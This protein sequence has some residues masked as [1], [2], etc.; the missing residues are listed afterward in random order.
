MIPAFE[1]RA[2]THLM[3]PWGARV[4]DLEELRR[5]VE[6]A[7]AEV[8]F[9]HTVQFPLRAPAAEQLP[10]DD[11]SAWVGGTL[12]DAE[13]AERLSFAVGTQEGGAAEMRGA[14]LA[15]IGSVPEKQRA[16]RRAP[17]GGELVFLAATSLS[18]PIGSAIHDADEMHDALIREEA[19]VWFYHLVEEPW[20]RGEAPLLAWLERAGDRRLADEIRQAARAGLPIEKARARVARRRRQR[21]LARRL[22]DAATQSEDQRREAGRQAVARFV[23]RGRR[24]EPGA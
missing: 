20:F 3:S 19:S 10:P 5:G 4:G 24:V 17:E 23:R 21:Q 13:T 16:A 6:A 9:R 18:F 1:L 14:L 8:L 15:V 2:V 11:L 7:P 22:A 12:Q